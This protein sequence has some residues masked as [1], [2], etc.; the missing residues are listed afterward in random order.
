MTISKSV[1]GK[2]YGVGVGP[3]DPGL[4]TLR[5][6]EVLKGV[7]VI[8]NV[9]GLNSKSSI[10]GSIVDSIT[11]CNAER[12]SLVFSMA[13]EMAERES[14][15]QKNSD[16]IISRL[17]EGKNC[18]FVTIGDPLLFSTY[19]YV[20]RKIMTAL[21]ALEVET[22]P[23]ITSFQA[24]A[25]S[26]NKP[27]VEDRQILAIVPAWKDE[28][29]TD[30]ILQSAD[31][32]VFL[33]TYKHKGEIIKTLEENNMVNDVVYAEHIGLT[34]EVIITDIEEVKKRKHEYLSL[35]IAH[36]NIK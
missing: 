5:A 20:L 13:K 9:V 24:V 6:A 22:V 18:A 17:Q 7:D 34:K 12:I 35:M 15:W 31:T 32:V 2:L 1:L 36:K 27:I 14:Y 4:L 33:K 19:T 29:V 23:G 21:P 3:G 25:A 26:Q 30:N 28:I 11:G 8:F 10:S 16:C